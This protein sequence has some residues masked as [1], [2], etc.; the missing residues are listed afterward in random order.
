MIQICNYMNNQQDV[1]QSV[2]TQHVMNSEIEEIEI[3]VS[4]QTITR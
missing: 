4:Q 1:T 3:K 2:V